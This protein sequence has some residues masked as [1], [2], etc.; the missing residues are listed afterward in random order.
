MITCKEVSDSASN[1]LDNPTT[2]LQKF[3][4]QVHLIMCVHCRRYVRQLKLTSQV[5]KQLFPADEPGDDEIESLIEKLK[6][7]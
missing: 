7:S 3:W 1:Y 5:A 4:L 6:Q 2:F